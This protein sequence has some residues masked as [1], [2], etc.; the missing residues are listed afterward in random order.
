[1]A[2]VLQLAELGLAFHLAFE[3]V[4]AVVLLS[5]ACQHLDPYQPRSSKTNRRRLPIQ[6]PCQSP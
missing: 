2:A 1:M 3:L 6:H 4:A 5:L